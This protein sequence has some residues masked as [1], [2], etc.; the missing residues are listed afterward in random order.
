MALTVS[1][2]TEATLNVVR[3]KVAAFHK[4]AVDVT[5]RNRIFFPLL[6]KWGGLKLGVDV[7]W[8]RV[9]NAKNK[10]PDSEEW[11]DTPDQD[12]PSGPE[13][14]QYSIGVGGYIS[15]DNL[16]EQ[17]YEMNSGSRT[18][19][20]NLY[21]EKAQDVQQ[22]IANRLNWSGLHAPGTGKH[23]SGMDTFLA[24]GTTVA[25]TDIVAKPD[26]TYAG[27]STA[28][29]VDGTWGSTLTTPPNASI[30][31][32]WPQVPL[33]GSPEY[34]WNSP[35]I[36][37]RN[38]PWDSGSDW[39]TNAFEVLRYWCS[40]NRN[41][42]AKIRDPKAYVT[43]VCGEAS[44]RQFKTLCD[45][46][47]YRLEPVAEA[48]NIGMPE[49]FYFEHSWLTIDSDVADDQIYMVQPDMM[50]F[51]TA[52]GFKQIWKMDGPYDFKPEF[53]SLYAARVLGNW[54][55]QPKFHG[56]IKDF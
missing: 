31:T 28:V 53:R 47:N 12:Y 5:L 55:W 46:R 11:L 14:Q 18:Q 9:W 54:R 25:A 45:S 16:S 30:G 36:L 19:I 13:Q 27:Q 48:I 23:M 7:S 56:Q 17:E 37:V 21:R 26:D 32:D 50:E 39:A 51:F 33:D 2:T 29:G 4:D 8:A 34:D 44:Q 10:L 1:Y 52:P 6:Q 3:S 20:F 49:T 35:L 24:T 42:G 15:K 22:A 41:R 43:G 40:V 38:G